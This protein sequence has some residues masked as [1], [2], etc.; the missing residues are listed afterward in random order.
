MML[1]P[2]ATEGGSVTCR[3]LPY[4]WATAPNYQREP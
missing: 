1:Y 4:S 3:A 2:L